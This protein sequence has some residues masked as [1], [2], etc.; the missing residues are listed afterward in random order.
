M[1]TQL[2]LTAQASG[3]GAGKLALSTTRGTVSVAASTTTVNSGTNIPVT[4]TGGGTA[5]TWWYRLAGSG[6]LGGAGNVTM[7]VRGLELALTANAGA[8]ILIQLYDTDGSTYLSDVMT[9]RTVP[10]AATE[11]TTADAAYN[12]V[13]AAT[14]TPYVD[15]QW[16]AVTLKVR[17]VGT[18]AAGT[19][20]NS[21]NGPTAAAAGDTYVTFADT[22]TEKTAPFLP[23]PVA[24]TV[25]EGDGVSTTVTPGLPAGTVAG[26]QLTAVVSFY[27]PELTTA[28]TLASINAPTGWIATGRTLIYQDTFDTAY[29]MVAEYK[30]IAVGSDAV[31]WTSNTV[32]AVGSNAIWGVVHR[33]PVDVNTSDPIQSAS[34]ASTSTTAT[35][36]SFTP[37][38]DNAFLLSVFSCVAGTG[39]D[40]WPT[41]H[42]IL[43]QSNN[44]AMA[45]SHSYGWSPQRAKAATGSLAFVHSVSGDSTWATLFT[46]YAQGVADQPTVPPQTRRRSA[47]LSPSRRGRSAPSVLPAPVVVAAPSFPPQPSRRRLGSLFRR[48]PVAPPTIPASSLPLPYQPPADRRPLF[49]VRRRSAPQ[50]IGTGS[51]STSPPPLQPSPRR[52]PQPLRRARAAAPTVITAA[53]VVTTQALPPQPAPRRPGLLARI[54]RVVA[55]LLPLARVPLPPQPTRRPTLL[56]G[57]RAK[58]APQIVAASV[59]P[60]APPLPAQPTG[61]R[62]VREASP[63]RRRAAPP[64]LVAAPPLIPQPARRPRTWLLRR[65]ASTPGPIPAGVVAPTTQALPPQAS[66]RRARPW[67][68]LRRR[69]SNPGYIAAGTVAPTTQALPPQPSTRR[70]GVLARAVRRAAL[71][72]IAAATSVVPQPAARRARV[73][74]RRRPTVAPLIPTVAP[75]ILP[76]PPTRRRSTAYVRRSRPAPLIPATRAATPIP[77]PPTR[78]RVGQRPT[79]RRGLAAPTIPARI[80]TPN[81]PLPPNPAR[82]R[83]PTMLRR[84]TRQPG[85]ITVGGVAPP[86]VKYPVTGSESAPFVVGIT[87]QK[88][89][90]LPVTGG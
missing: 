89:A 44:A 88:R 11:Y 76:P 53:P 41:G 29:I 86:V 80:I 34:N 21:Y 87:G 84:R 51:A 52:R 35:I 39:T 47:A 1:A 18:M 62:I 79:A 68:P 83:P 37:A 57:R 60:A 74:A 49:G 69:P 54:K 36:G 71:P 9:D 8:G 3:L 30:K 6:T 24:G 28:P 66:P 20:V 40:T 59:A 12:R 7:N 38:R 77:T 78:R 72:V 13:S 22:L 85:F 45:T 10:S 17:N 75:L 26:S 81:P 27:W 46:Y 55:P 73:T 33:W 4:D 90:T 61:R 50:V 16:I 14:S 31:N 56:T 2:F 19:V 67:P 48:R 63:R 42:A 65:R 5:I 32:G 15:G 23:V 64:V 82:R 70:Q 43:A 58:V 25:Y